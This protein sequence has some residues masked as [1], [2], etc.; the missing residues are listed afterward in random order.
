MGYL[1]TCRKKTIAIFTVWKKNASNPREGSDRK[2]ATKETK[3]KYLQNNFNL[4]VTFIYYY[5]LVNTD[6]YKMIQ[7]ENQWTKCE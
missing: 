7:I 2:H 6:I 5:N 1:R 4:F 3:H